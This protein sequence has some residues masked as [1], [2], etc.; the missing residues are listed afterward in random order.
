MHA[1]ERA[2]VRARAFVPAAAVDS[3]STHFLNSP[4]AISMLC[5]RWSASTSIS[6]ERSVFV[7]LTVL[8]PRSPPKSSTSSS[9]TFESARIVSARSLERSVRPTVDTK[10]PSGPRPCVL[11]S[12]IFASLPSEAA[13][14]PETGA[15]VPSSSSASGALMSP[16]PNSEGW[17]AMCLRTD[18]ASSLLYSRCPA[19]DADVTMPALAAS[20]Q[21]SFR[22]MSHCGKEGK[23]Q[24][25]P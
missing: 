6:G 5:R 20:S 3:A 8:P 22:S 23:A 16:L 14:S 1:H 7:T 9:T 13:A 4:Q 25:H 12:S 17:A 21:V 24:T 15:S 18:L 19:I 11:F 10:G 2:Q